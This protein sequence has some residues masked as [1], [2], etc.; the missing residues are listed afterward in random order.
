MTAE[1][2]IVLFTVEVVGFAIATTENAVTP[3]C[4]VH[5]V[6]FVPVAVTATVRLEDVVKV[7]P[8][9][10]W[11]NSDKVAEPTWLKVCVTDGTCV[12]VWPVSLKIQLYVVP[13][14]CEQ[15]V[16]W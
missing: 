13:E 2:E 16:D 4:V 3:F 15:G 14:N 8:Q 5:E 10:S 9:V 7:S 1:N 6:P 11:T 12:W